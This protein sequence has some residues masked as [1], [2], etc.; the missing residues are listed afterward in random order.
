MSRDEPFQPPRRI[1]PRAVASFL[2]K[3]AVGRTYKT[4]GQLYDERG[5]LYEIAGLLQ[6]ILKELREA[7]EKSDDHLDIHRDWLLYLRHHNV[8]LLDAHAAECQRL[9]Q[10][11]TDMRLLGEDVYCASI[12]TLSELYR[13]DRWDDRV[14]LSIDSRYE[15]ELKR[16]RDKVKRLSKVHSLDDLEHLYGIG[17]KTADRIREKIKQEEPNAVI[18]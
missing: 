5:G 18:H 14:W 17:K 6:L 3:N 10:M 9:S 2:E 12:H 13:E 11:V 8:G 4:N 7:K 1:S 16:I 15:K